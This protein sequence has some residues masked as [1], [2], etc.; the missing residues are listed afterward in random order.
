VG[1]KPKYGR[2]ETVSDTITIRGLRLTGYHGVLDHEKRDGQEFVIDLEI[3]LDLSSAGSTDE[4]QKTLDYSV[5]VDQVAQRVT[6]ESVDL[7]ETLAHD[8]AQ[9]VLNHPQSTAVTV[10]VHKP[11][12]PVAH[13]LQDI[14]VTITREREQS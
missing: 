12:A 10:T 4:L 6:G 11:Q 13:P 3:E 1:E 14:A 5:V 9:I 8:L 7:I 2:V